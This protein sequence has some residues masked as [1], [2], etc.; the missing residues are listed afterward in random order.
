MDIDF[1][2]LYH[3]LFETFEGVGILVVVGLFLGLVACV[4]MELRTRRRFK[5]HE[6]VED[7][8]DWSFFDD[9]TH[10]PKTTNTSTDSPT[11]Q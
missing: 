4:I 9:E 2:A 11:R 1:G 6:E 10:D 7:D 8:D 3:F 5:N